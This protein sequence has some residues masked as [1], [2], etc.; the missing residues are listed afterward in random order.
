M[1]SHLSASVLN[2]APMTVA[3]LLSLVVVPMMACAETTQDI[4]DL[5]L[6][7]L[8]DDVVSSASKYEETLEESPAN[9]FIV[10]R[11]MI[12][13]YGCRTI[14]DALSLVPGI[15]ITDDYSLSQIGVRGIA[16][17]GDWNSRMMVLVDGRSLTEQYGGSNSIDV[18]GLDLDN[19][20]RIEV[21]KG[22]ASSLY[23]SNAFFGIVNLI[24]E[25][26]TENELFV[27][28][29]YFRN[30]DQK[31]SSIRLYQKFDNGLTALIT[32]SYLDRNGSD[33][34]FK[35]FSDL[36]DGAILRLDED[37]YNQFYLDSAD[38]TGGYSHNK[39]S[40]ENYAFRSRLG[41]GCFYLTAHFAQQRSGISHGFYGALFNRSENEYN[42][43]R[44]FLDLGYQNS[45]SENS[46]LSLR[47]SYDH[48]FWSDHI[49]YNYY[50][51]E[52]EPLYLP[53]P[54]WI[55]AEY[56]Q[57]YSSEA[58]LQ[59]DFG[60]RNRAVFGVEV[61]LHE[62][63]HESGE[64]DQAGEEIQENVIPPGSVNYS[65]QIYNV[66]VQDEHRFSEKI[67]F[68]GGLHFNHFTYTTGRV[69]PKGALILS[70][71]RH[72]T[73]KLIAS[74]GFRSPT[75]YEVSFDDGSY[76]IGNPDLSPEL[77]TSYEA[78][79]THEFPYGF[80]V[81]VA[82]NLS[83]ASD[84]IVQTVIDESDPAHPGSDYV[85]EVS[86][87]RNTGKMQSSS[88]ELSLQRNPI[89][90]LSGFANVTYQ[91]LETLGDAQTD[92][93]FNSPR[94][95]GNIGLTYQISRNRMSLSTKANY[96]SSR[97]LWDHSFVDG[98]MTM[99]VIAN[100]RRVL[101]VVDVTVGIMNV[102][103]SDYRVP[104]NYDYA[105]STSIQRPR[106]SLY[107][108]LKSNFN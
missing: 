19:I 80:V 99:D 9:V 92:Q 31:G 63:M 52:D 59:V 55:D 62:I 8:L 44:Y 21:I 50:S 93:P 102:F 54:T 103:D 20:D 29:K 74:Q 76:F 106:R 56:D 71:Y 77:I 14:G 18:V 6:Q 67:K 53:G 27:S 45:L 72:G 87:F 90:S 4:A 96:I 33:L 47:L 60:D 82:G 43:R 49:L 38:F 41:L 78:I 81:E 97:R 66:Y 42:E 1:K 26:P 36:G 107:V 86:Q 79:S 16:N 12:E 51:D 70:P 84:L 13:S 24:T 3:L 91:K 89:Y 105:P 61:Q 39:N 75:F 98:Q 101:S 2:W 32:G 69:T 64:T 108:N 100:F 95:L 85:E 5:D 57:W 7:S 40:S 15:Y 11:A 88:L 28:S 104:L 58:R 34:F 46:E 30:T 65:G 48:F 35:E 23:G 68:V 83:R 25:Q 94:W 10:S 73:Y 37:G 22:P 17:F